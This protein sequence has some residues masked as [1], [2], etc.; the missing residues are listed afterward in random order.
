MEVLLV[1]IGG[2]AGATLRY[3]VGQLVDGTS[4]PWATLVV[5]ALGSFVLGA[6]TVGVSDA[7]ALLIVSV[8]FCGAFTTF[9]SFSFQTVSLW[10]RGE[11]RT[12]VLNA[13]GNLVVSLVAFAAAWQLVP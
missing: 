2:A 4:F 7:D 9:S 13:V 3:L 6:V 5:N 1:S 11:K 12:A 8:G 10:D